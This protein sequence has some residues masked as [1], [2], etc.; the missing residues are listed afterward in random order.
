V[1]T[2]DLTGVETWP[3]VIAD[4]P[5]IVRRRCRHGDQCA[6]LW[7]LD[8]GPPAPV[9]SSDGGSN[10]PRV[11]RIDGGNLFEEALVRNLDDAPGPPVP[12]FDQHV[13]L[14]IP[15]VD[16]V[17]ADRPDVIRSYYGDATQAGEGRSVGVGTTDQEIPSQCSISGS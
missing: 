13:V 15:S 8:L 7:G 5:D 11:L 2:E 14:G 9:P 16:P 3:V 10:G 6:E 12:M 17:G 1:L 4:R